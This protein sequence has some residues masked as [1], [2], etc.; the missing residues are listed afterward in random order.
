MVEVTLVRGACHLFNAIRV[1]Q[2]HTE[3]ANA[4]HTGLGADGRLTGLDTRVTE[5]ALLGL[6]AFP[7]VVDLLVGAAGDTHPPAAALVLVD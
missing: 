2:Q 1:I 5:N 4:A 7:V 3:V 6:T